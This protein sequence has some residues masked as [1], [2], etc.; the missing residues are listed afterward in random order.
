M[1]SCARCTREVK[2]EERYLFVGSDYCRA[3]INYIENS[4]EYETIL[5]THAVLMRFRQIE[6]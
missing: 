3:C 5:N 2:N 1:F 4:G 6:N